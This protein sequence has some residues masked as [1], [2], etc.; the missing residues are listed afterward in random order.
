M[1]PDLYCSLF[2]IDS[3]RDTHTP[4]SDYYQLIFTEYLLC[5]T[6]YSELFPC[7]LFNPHNNLMRYMLFHCLI[8]EEKEAQSC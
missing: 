7:N 6:P 4:Y 8:D 2:I 1:F 5:T 3:E